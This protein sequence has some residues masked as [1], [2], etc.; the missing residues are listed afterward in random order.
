MTR[1]DMVAVVGQAPAVGVLVAGLESP[2]PHVDAV[3][4]EGVEVM[5]RHHGGG[6]GGGFWTPH[7]G[8]EFLQKEG[9][10]IKEKLQQLLL[11]LE[12][13]GTLLSCRQNAGRLS[14]EPP[15]LPG[16]CLV[17]EMR[18]DGWGKRQHCEGP[19]AGSRGRPMA[20]NVLPIR[21]ACCVYPGSSLANAC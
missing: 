2:V 20:G 9:A 14:G 21:G 3:L 13:S 16:L 8:P 11:Q 4:A 1:D 6:Q 5:N 10:I 17:G 18:V 7:A 12:A 15:G 19:A